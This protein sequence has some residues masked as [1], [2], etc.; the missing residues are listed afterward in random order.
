MAESPHWRYID[1]QRGYLRCEVDVSR[2]VSSLRLVDTVW[3]PTA[4]IRTAAEF[5][6]ESG[7][8][9]IA[10]VGSRSPAA[11]STLVAGPVYDVHD[12]QDSHPLH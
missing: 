1:N 11:R 10:E 7:R 4:G 12:D 2:M 8:P 5:V 3:A 9:G 6:V